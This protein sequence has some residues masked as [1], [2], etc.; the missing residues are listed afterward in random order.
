MGKYERIV[1]IPA[2]QIDRKT[3][4]E[5]AAF[6]H[7][8]AEQRVTAV[9]RE[10]LQQTFAPPLPLSGVMAVVTANTIQTQFAQQQVE[11]YVASEPYRNLIRPSFGD[12]YTFLSPHGNVQFLFEDFNYEDI[13]PDVVTAIVE[14]A[15][16]AGEVLNLNLRANPRVV[17]FLDPNINRVLIQGPDRAWVNDTAQKFTTLFEKNK[18]PLRNVVY[19]WTPVFVWASFFAALVIE[20]KAM[21]FSTGFR[22]DLPLNGLEL[23]AVFGAL[24]GTL[25]LSAHFFTQ[26]MPFVYPYFELENNLSRKRRIW[27]WPIV[28]LI[29]FLYATALALLFKGH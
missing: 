23:L 24:V 11:E 13:P 29:S 7:A 5:V 8:L 16:P 2:V 1:K 27:R 14:S 9:L 21:R 20:Y 28:G 17:D 26:L 12:K 3:A 18:E 22:W 4:E 15:G 10:R 25:V 19:R 6:V